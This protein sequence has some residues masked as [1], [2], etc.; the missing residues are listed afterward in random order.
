M[1]LAAFIPLP[2]EKSMA[3]SSRVE[4]CL[5]EQILLQARDALSVA[6]FA[7]AEQLL[8]TLTPSEVST[9]EVDLLRGRC[10]QFQGNVAAAVPLYHRC[11][12][13]SK[14]LTDAEFRWKACFALS[15]AHADLQESL[16]AKQYFQLAMTY[17]FE[18]L[19]SGRLDHLPGE[20]ML[21][22]A[23]NRQLSGHDDGG[24]VELLRLRVR[25]SDP[26]LLARIEF[27]LADAHPGR[28][29]VKWLEKSWRNFQRSGDLFNAMKTL[30]RLSERLLAF[31][32]W[33]EGVKTLRIARDFAE[34]L[35][36][37]TKVAEY[38]A[39]LSRLER[40][41]RLLAGHSSWN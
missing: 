32:A 15:A 20:V 19:S 3:Y 17:V 21:A 9:P 28:S 41:M 23:F 36:L 37:R 29:G 26:H 18:E 30:E 38:A 8:D 24:C 1:T 34:Q 22:N 39:L 4:S 33:G 16:Q 25:T 31:R 5:T 7:F 27:C 13:A 35:Q 14:R 6:D 10:Q 40:S 2:G 11:W 12:E